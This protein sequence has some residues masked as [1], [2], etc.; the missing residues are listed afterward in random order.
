METI[1]QYDQ[2]TVVDGVCRSPQDMIK[3]SN[4]SNLLK[5]QEVMNLM[6]GRTYTLDEALDRVIRF[7]SK[8]VPFN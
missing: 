3:S 4:I 2:C 7:Y 8:F 5:I 6:E 1:A